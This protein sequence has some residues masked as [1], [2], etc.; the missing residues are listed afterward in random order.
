MTEPLVIV[1][2]VSVTLYQR[3]VLNS[4]SM[5]LSAGDF[6]TLRGAN[7][8]GK[9]TL[10]KC[11]LGLR[12]PS[13]GVIR[14]T[15]GA[16]SAGYVPQ[17]PHSAMAMPLRVRDVVS[18]GRCAHLPFWRRPGAQDTE[19]VDRAM[20]TVGIADLASRPIRMLSGGEQ[21]KV[22][23]ARVLAQEPRVLLLDEPTV[24]LDTRSRQ[25]FIDLLARIFRESNLAVMMVT[26]DEH[27][28]PG[29]CTQEIELRGGERYG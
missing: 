13:S 2:Q 3:S 19:A 20:R 5:T 1:D 7:G 29:C 6:I 11:I 26:H 14:R 4:V 23:L 8:A 24:H 9:T 18:I 15:C 21:Q 17:V 10:L 12:R 27:A 28:V 22:Q 16:G 25:E